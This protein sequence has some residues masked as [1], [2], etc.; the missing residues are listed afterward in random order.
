MEEEVSLV[1]DWETVEEEEV[2]LVGDWETVV[3]EEA[4]WETVEEEEASLVEDWETEV[5]EEGNWETVEEE[6]ASLEG[7]WETVAEEEASWET[8]EEEASWETVGAGWEMA[9]EEEVSLEMV[10]M[11]EL[12]GWVMM[13]VEEE[14]DMQHNRY[15]WATD[16]YYPM[17]MRYHH[18]TIHTQ[19]G[20]RVVSKVEVGAR[21]VH[22]RTACMCH[23]L[24]RSKQSACT[25]LS[26]HW[27]DYSKDIDSLISKRLCPDT[28]YS[29]CPIVA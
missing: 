14:C 19:F 13:M 1:E 18:T 20:F 3:E 29:Y 4:S 9:V 22:N 27:L 2:S 26:M 7:D 17:L 25:T 5:E 6:E 12:A 16:T 11:E 8:V 24:H 28:R 21:V 15:M 23:R 10:V